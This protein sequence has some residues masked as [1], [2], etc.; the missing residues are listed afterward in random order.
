VARVLIVGCGCRGRELAAALIA[1]GHTVRGTTRSEESLAAIEETGAEAVVADPDR[2]ATILARLDGVS[3]VCWLM[4]S[5]AGADAVHGVRLET[6]LERLVDTPV[7]GFLYEASGSV[8][9]DLLQR[10]T[11]LVRAAGDRYRMPVEV[12][13]ADPTD[14]EA[15]LTEMIRAVSELLGGRAGS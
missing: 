6:L 15:W 13:D 4:G 7:R 3:A 12:V 11:K 9:R 2:L 14:R 1:S 8:P 10:G 5:A